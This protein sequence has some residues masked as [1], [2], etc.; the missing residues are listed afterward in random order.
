MM[1]R[2]SQS[3]SAVLVASL[4]CCLLLAWCKTGVGQDVEVASVALPFVATDFPQTRLPT[5]AAGWTFAN[6]YQRVSAT[7]K[8]GGSTG[9]LELVVR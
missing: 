4:T 8:A 1:M 6:T 9:V 2:T 7:V 5:P 3:C